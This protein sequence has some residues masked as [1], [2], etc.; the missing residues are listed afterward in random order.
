MIIQS[1]HLLLWN[2]GISFIHYIHSFR[3]AIHP[4]A[5]STR[6]F[7]KFSISNSIFNSISKSLVWKVSYHYC[8]TSF[9]YA[10]TQVL[11]RF[12]PCSRRVGD[13]RWWGSLTMV[14]AGNK[15]NHLSSVNHT[16]KTIHNHHHHHHHHWKFCKNE[17]VND[18]FLNQKFSYSLENS[19]KLN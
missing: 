1:S 11:C 6:F 7:V 15:A 4:Y 13:L 16:T 5:N 8:T 17:L 19:A 10:W 14:P 3:L 18:S 12:K 9:N 2:I